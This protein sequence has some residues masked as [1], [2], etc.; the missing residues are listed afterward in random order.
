MLQI[1]AE[2]MMFGAPIKEVRLMKRK[3]TG[4]P[5]TRSAPLHPGLQALFDVQSLAALG[6]A[7][8]SQG[9]LG[10]ALIGQTGPTSEVQL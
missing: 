7:I 3:D 8:I 4:E 2:L 9:K 10:V 1:R 6:L 5:Q